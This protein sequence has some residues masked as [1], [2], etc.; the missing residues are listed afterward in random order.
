MPLSEF[1][2]FD[3]YQIILEIILGLERLSQ[4]GDFMAQSFLWPEEQGASCKL[5]RLQSQ[6]S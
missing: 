6:Q 4:M 1:S 3:F 5:D 2:D